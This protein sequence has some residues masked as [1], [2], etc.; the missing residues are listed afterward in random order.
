[1]NTNTDMQCK[2][3]T[4]TTRRAALLYGG[5]YY[6][7]AVGE[8]VCPWC[9]DWDAACAEATQLEEEE[10][11]QPKLEWT[12][13][14]SVLDSWIAEKKDTKWYLTAMEYSNTYHW[15]VCHDGE[16]LGQGNEPEL[17]LAQMAA[18]EAFRRIIMDANLLL[19][20]LLMV[21]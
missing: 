15:S 16:T 5:R 6:D 17:A 8:W 9:A 2:H 21:K 20:D 19:S 1:M 3:I 10:E 14:D 4:T 7:E 18:E 11:S 13:D 12:K